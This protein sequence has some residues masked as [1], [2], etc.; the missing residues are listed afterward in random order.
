[1]SPDPLGSI[2]RALQVEPVLIFLGGP[3]CAGKSTFFEAFLAQLGLPFVN[4]DRIA[5]AVREA[6]PAARQAEVD[7]RAFEQAE[8]FRSDFVDAGVSFCT[9]SV[10]SDPVGAKVG[11]LQTAQSKGF[12]VFLIFIGLDTPS[13]SAAR[14]H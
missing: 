4:A 8:R 5:L 7:R 9:E 2:R 11:A 10:F 13:L 12:A 1:M 6:D 3:N 14:V